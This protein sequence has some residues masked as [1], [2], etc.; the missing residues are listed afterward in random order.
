M[1]SKETANPSLGKL[2]ISEGPKGKAGLGSS[3]PDLHRPHWVGRRVHTGNEE[4]LVLEPQSHRLSAGALLSAAFFVPLLVFCLLVT[5][6]VSLTPLGKGLS[7][8]PSH[9]GR[10]FPHEQELW[11]FST[12]FV[13]RC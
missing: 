7:Q 2:S 8:I 1:I 5:L 13:F 4:T 11:F 12:D 10:G 6:P 3:F 9:L